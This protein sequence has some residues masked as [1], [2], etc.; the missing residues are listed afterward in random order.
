[1]LGIDLEGGRIAE[2]DVVAGKCIEAEEVE[3]E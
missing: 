2:I 3:F 1:M